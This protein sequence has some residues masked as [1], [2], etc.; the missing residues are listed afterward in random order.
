MQV[1]LFLWVDTCLDLGGSFD[2]QAKLCDFSQSHAYEP[3]P[4]YALW[5]SFFFASAVAVF[6]WARK[7]KALNA[8]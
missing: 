4:S 6:A 8:V 3:Q 1:A 2:Y 5:G 7:R